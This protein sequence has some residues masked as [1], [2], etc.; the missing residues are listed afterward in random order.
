MPQ[1]SQLALV[2]QSQWLWLLLVLAAIYFVVGRGIVSKVE[3]TVDD[4]DARI[5][6]D[7]AEVQRLQDQAEAD[8]EAWRNRVNAMREQA[9]GV[10][11]SAKADAQASLEARLAVVDTEIAARADAA[12][13]E[14]DAARGAALAELESVAVEATQ[15]IVERLTGASV[16]EAEAR[17]A[18][19]GALGHA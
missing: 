7:L 15:Q 14:L 3:S 19:T 17:A 8:E 1:L 11:A 4:R 16:A 13:A 12:V 10:T 18:V 2:I 5:A 9:Q 6:A